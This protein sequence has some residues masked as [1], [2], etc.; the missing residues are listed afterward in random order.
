VSVVRVRRQFTF[1]AAHR[2]PQHPG[3][4]RELHGHSYRLV[5]SVERPVDPV[6]GLGIDFSDLKAVVRREVVDRLDHRFAGSLAG[7]HEIELHETR[8]CS[9]VYRGE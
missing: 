5:V 7:L 9:V 3:K 1:E 6:S 4:C 8:D 2:L